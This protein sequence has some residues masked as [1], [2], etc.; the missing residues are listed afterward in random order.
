MSSPWTQLISTA[1]SSE[2]VTW[3]I[4]AIN[5]RRRSCDEHEH[6]TK[7]VVKARYY[8]PDRDGE[9]LNKSCKRSYDKKSD[10]GSN[11]VRQGD[12]SESAKI[13]L[14]QV[15]WTF[16][17]AYL[18]HKCC[19]SSVVRPVD[20]DAGNPFPVS[21]LNY[22]EA[23]LMSPKDYQSPRQTFYKGSTLLQIT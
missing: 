7:I 10:E 14:K 19:I 16:I 1:F 8:L 23:K 6:L 11:W 21:S 18:W 15:K 3:Y 4:Y 9:Q 13:V 12:E 17:Y 5:I 20:E 22:S 2:Y